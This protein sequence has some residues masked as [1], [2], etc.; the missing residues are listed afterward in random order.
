MAQHR[1]FT[2]AAGTAHVLF[3]DRQDGDFQLDGDPWLREAAARRLVDLPWS[4]VRQVHRADVV[5]VGE[6]GGGQGQ[7]GDGL[8][9][10]VAGAVLSVRGADCPMVGFVSSEGVVGVAHAGWR[11]LLAGVLEQTVSTMRDQGATAVSAL[12]G[13]CISPAHYAF[14]PEDLDR[15]TARFGPTVR[16]TTAAGRPAVDL[17]AAV[18]CALQPLAVVLD[19]TTHRCTARDGAYFSHRARGELGRQTTAVWLAP[20]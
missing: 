14:G 12:L 18:A 11:G 10:T 5:V 4:W 15:L 13:P 2:T 6:P 7:D 17:L 16:A 1:C 8:V 3:T 19:T 20:P 9:T